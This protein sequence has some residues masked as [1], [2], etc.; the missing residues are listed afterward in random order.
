MPEQGLEENSLR[1]RAKR[2][3]EEGLSLAGL[4]EIWGVELRGAQGAMLEAW[5][6]EVK[7]T[8]EVTPEAWKTALNGS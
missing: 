7:E 5:R 2:G 8:G 4:T 3:L 1:L 6:F